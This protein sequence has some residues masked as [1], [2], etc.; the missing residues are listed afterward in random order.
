MVAAPDERRQ[1]LCS[2]VPMSHLCSFTYAAFALAFVYFVLFI[3]VLRYLLNLMRSN[4]TKKRAQ[5]IFLAILIAQTLRQSNARPCGPVR[6]VQPPPCRQ[7]PVRRQ[8][9]RGPEATVGELLMIC[10]PMLSLYS[11][12]LQF[13]FFIFS[14]SRSARLPALRR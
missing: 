9:G 11:F 1:P 5:K 14:S 2:A 8:I 12:C 3:L 4:S 10:V 6:G 7:R 13:A